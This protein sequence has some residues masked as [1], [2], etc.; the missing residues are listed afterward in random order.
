L[1]FSAELDADVGAVR[2]GDVDGEREEVGE[3]E[4]EDE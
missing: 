1:T 2:E 3:E 4:E